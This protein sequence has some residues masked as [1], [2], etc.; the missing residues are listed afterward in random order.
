M[1]KRIF[2]VQQHRPK[3]IAFSSKRKAFLQ[4]ETKKRP[5]INRTETLEKER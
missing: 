4:E 1:S 2:R 3:A 5:T